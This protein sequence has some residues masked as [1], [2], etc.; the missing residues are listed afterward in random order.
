MAARVSGADLA[1]F[2]AIIDEM[3]QAFR[4]KDFATLMA[5]HVPDEDVCSFGLT[6][7]VASKAALEKLWRDFHQHYL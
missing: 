1:P 3:H 6:E 4:E 2:K 5:R 7:D